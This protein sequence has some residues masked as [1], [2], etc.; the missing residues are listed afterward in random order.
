MKKIFKLLMLLIITATSAQIA[1]AAEPQTNEVLKAIMSR[2]SVRTYTDQAVE[3]SK[4]EAMLKAAM[5][6]PT[7]SNKQP[8]EFV[9]VT[10]RKALDQIPSIIAGARGASRAQLAIVVLGNPSTSTNWLLDCS[11]ATENL[12]L[13][14]HSMGLGA[15]W[16]GAYPDNAEGRVGKLRS[17]LSFSEDLVPLNV[18]VIGYPNTTPSI[19]DKWDPAKVHYV[20]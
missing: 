14:A 12:L 2:S 10:N 19:K 11:A 20:K 5:A 16:C 7:G 8:W 3:S 17:L 4:I 13:A 1:S 15:V 9:V 18:I 6:A